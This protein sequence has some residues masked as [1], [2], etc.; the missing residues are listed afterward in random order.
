MEMKKRRKKIQAPRVPASPST[1]LI[2][3]PGAK[4]TLNKGQ[5]TFNRLVRKLEKLRRELEETNAD[6]G[7]KLAFYGQNIHPLEQEFAALRQ[8]GVKAL[9]SFYQD[10]KLLSKKDRATLRKMIGTQLSA[11]FPYLSDEPDD[12]LKEIFA[13]VEGVSYEQAAAEDFHTMKDDIAGIFSQMG[14]DVDLGGFRHDMTEEEAMRQMRGILDNLQEQAETQD[15]APPKRKPTKKQLEREARAQQVEEAKAKNIATIYKQLA[16]VL[17][18]DLEPDPQRKEQ[19]ENLMKQLTAAY[20]KGDLHALLRLELE[21]I[22]KEESNL[23]QLSGEKLAIYNQVLQ[24]QVAELQLEIRLAAEHPRYAPLQQLCP[25]FMNLR[26]LN[27]EREKRALQASL[28]DVRQSLVK[29]RSAN[30]LPELKSLLRAFA[31][32]MRARNFFEMSFDDFFE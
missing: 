4:E 23:D 1:K 10:K 20:D 2:I 31:Q 11:V 22:H 7:R 3:G 14:F 21:W 25:P 18:P 26:H 12:E 19:K 17:H 5:Q 15:A 9:Y 6:L 30:P 28:R 16:R 29:L 8:E 24:E 13:A 32:Q 27:L